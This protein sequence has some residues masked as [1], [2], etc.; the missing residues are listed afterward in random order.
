MW[1]VEYTDEFGIWWDSLQPAEQDGSR[2]PWNCSRTRGRRLEG[3]SWAPSG[4]SASPHEG[5][6]PRDHA[7][8]LR[9]RSTAV[10]HPASRRRQEWPLGGMVCGR[11]PGGRS[12]VRR[13]SRAVFATKGWAMTSRIPEPATT[14][15]TSSVRRSMADSQRRARVEG[16][17]TQML[18]E[19]RRE[20]D[21][22]QVQLADRLDVTQENVSQIR[23]RPDPT[24]ACPALTHQ[25][26][27]ALGGR[28]ELKATFPTGPSL[29]QS[30]PRGSPAGGTR[31]EAQIEPQPRQ[32][33]G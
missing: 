19:L 7:S 24:C 30:T 21:L 22:T 28:L 10:G 11:R 15:S 17:K 18:G 14:A 8:A 4:S 20:L 3:P 33:H 29:S 5:T 31:P 6:P 32:D 1:E 26:V 16:Y 23:A 13:A 2:P 25:Y 9:L 27:E 12:A